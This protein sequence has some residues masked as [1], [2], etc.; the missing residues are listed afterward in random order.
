MLKQSR[1]LVCCIVQSLLEKLLRMSPCR[2]INFMQFYQMFWEWNVWQRNLFRHCWILFLPEDLKVYKK[3]YL[4]LMCRLRE[5]IGTMHDFR[6]T[7][8]HL[9]THRWLCGIVWQKATNQSCL[10][11][12]IQRTWSLVT[13][14]CSQNWKD[15]A[16]QRLRRCRLLCWR[17]SSIHT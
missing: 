7:V 9:L 5:A 16:L 15:G 2:L 14:S 8:M 13:Y 6:I 12:R 4:E 11:L 10:S 3:Y 17:T 1:K